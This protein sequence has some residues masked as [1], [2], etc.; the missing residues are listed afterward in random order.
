MWCDLGT[1]FSW[2]CACLVD[3]L[4]WLAV[5][6]HRPVLTFSDVRHIPLGLDPKEEVYSCTSSL[7]PRPTLTPQKRR[8]Q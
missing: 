8:H 2:P 1:F 6:R 4:S 5:P 3:R 7:V